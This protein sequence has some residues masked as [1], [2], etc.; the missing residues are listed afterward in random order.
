V[1]GAFE[2]GTSGCSISVHYYTLLCKQIC[3]NPV[4][5][6]SS[7]MQ[8]AENGHEMSKFYLNVASNKA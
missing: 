8:V 1:T 3:H 5:Y 6:A 7:L 4:R 2:E